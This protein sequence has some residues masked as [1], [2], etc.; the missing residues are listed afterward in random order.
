[1]THF[2]RYAATAFAALFATAS[3]CV[4]AADGDAL[5]TIRSKPRDTI[6]VVAHRGAGDL[7]P[8]NCLSSLELTW[9]M[10]GVPEVDVRTTKDGR[11]MMFHDGNFQRVCPN[12]SEEIRKSSVEKMTYDEVRKLDIGIFRGEEHRGE[13]V[14]SI[15][16]IVEAL[17]A[18]SKRKVVIDVKNVDFQKLSDAVAD[19]REQVILTSGSEADLQRWAKIN[20]EF[21]DTALWMGLGS[22]T[23]ADVE[24][25]FESLR[26]NDFAGIK[27][28]Q[29]HVT[30]DADG[31]L[32][33]SAACIRACANE[34]RER[35]I[36]FQTMPWRTKTCP[37]LAT[38]IPFHKEL[39]NLG[40]MG[41]GTDRPDCAFQALDEFYAEAPQK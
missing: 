23:D 12:E 32:K 29:I 41:F 37:E 28:L 5:W 20:V 25:R 36:E 16:D 4:L 19:V 39:L 27:R 38:D 31:S 13:R 1:M 10:G 11:I 17:K 21:Y 14:L 33:P 34:C 40:T 15:E 18:D 35:G 26:K 24:K 2:F 8:E 22:Y 3:A 7:A 30:K 6:T 9:K